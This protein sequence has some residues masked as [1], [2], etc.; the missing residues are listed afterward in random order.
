M[1]ARI[2]QKG[3]YTPQGWQGVLDSSFSDRK[4]AIHATVEALGG[5][6]EAI[7]FSSTADWD[8]MVIADGLEPNLQGKAQILASGSYASIVV[9]HVVTAEEADGQDD[10]VKHKTA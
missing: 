3:T 9:E 8:W 7:Y 1:M 2:I 4:A 5:T 10:S 6:V